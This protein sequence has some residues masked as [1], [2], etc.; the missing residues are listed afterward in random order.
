M[1]IIFSCFFVLALTITIW[2]KQPNNT[3]SKTDIFVAE[4]SADNALTITKPK[5]K[6]EDNIKYETPPSN[7]LENNKIATEETIAFEDID[8]EEELALLS[9]SEESLIE[10]PEYEIFTG[11][12]SYTG[13]DTEDNDAGNSGFEDDFPEANY[14]YDDHSAEAYTTYT[15]S[16]GD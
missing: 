13:D 7:S 8:I 11:N 6:K 14:A 12:S 1:P 2:L 9:L 4:E 16:Y 3:S 10:E 5:I 15:E